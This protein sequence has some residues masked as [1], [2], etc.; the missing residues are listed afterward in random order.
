MSNAKGRAMST[1]LRKF[2]LLV[3]CL[4]VSISAYTQEAAVDINASYKVPDLDIK[5]WADRFEV[6]GREV[7]DYRNE[8][9]EVLAIKKGQVVADVG[10]GTGL[11]VP[12][13]A[14]EV[15]VEGTLY[16]VDIIP[17]FIEHIKTRA[18]NSQLAQVKTVLSNE[19]SVELAAN[20]IDIV[21]TSDVYHHFVYYQEM[22]A[23]I[24]SALREG[25]QFVI[26]EFDRVPGKS[27]KFIL[28][29]IRASKE[30]FTAEVEANGFRLEED[31]TLEGM[32]ETFI[33]RFIKQ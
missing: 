9:V 27:S 21:F 17:K 7:F 12:L 20:S 11:F 10:A 16:A 22:L 28:D 14:N 1:F 15:G 5:A 18:A 23:S 24:H 4:L 13:L 30:V 31:I 19:H 33:R 29:H 32:T 26:V 8:I 6:E 2:I 25:G 3:A